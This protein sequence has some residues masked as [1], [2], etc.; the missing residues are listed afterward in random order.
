MNPIDKNPVKGVETQ[1]NTHNQDP[2]LEK[3]FIN[4]KILL[5]YIQQL[6]RKT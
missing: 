2:N 5:K 3:K 6:E 4:A 1:D